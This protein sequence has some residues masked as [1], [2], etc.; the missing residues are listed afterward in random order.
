MTKEKDELNI[1][2]PIINSHG[3]D[4]G[5]P[6]RICPKCKQEKPLDKF[7]FRKMSDGTIRN[8]SWCRECR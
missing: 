3:W 7:G 6:T 2:R 8:Q 1:Q 5:Q 4:G